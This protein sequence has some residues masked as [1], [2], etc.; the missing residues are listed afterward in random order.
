MTDFTMIT[1]DEIDQLAAALAQAQSETPNAVTNRVNPHFKNAYADLAAIRDATLPALTKYGLSIVQTPTLTPD[2]FMLISRLLHRSGQ[3]IESIYPV[4][5]TTPQ[6]R[7][8]ELTYARRYTWSA[9]TGVSAEEDD[10]AEVAEASAKAPR[11]SASEITREG[12]KQLSKAKSR[13]LYDTLIKEMRSY[14]E[15]R[16]LQT[17]G[18]T[19]STRI[20]S[21][22]EEH[23]RFFRQEYG[24]YLT[25]LKEGVDETGKPTGEQID[26]E[27]PE[28]GATEPDE[29]GEEPA[30]QGK[31]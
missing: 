1:S 5:G 14:K 7:G 19:N 16:A 11:N 26:D 9:L 6:A 23:G 10:D 4:A 3:F 13:P 18:L 28:P 15:P 20:H 21:M 2:G 12:D 24:D 31:D 25:A 30:T 8:S 29:T 22:H 27:V 17:W